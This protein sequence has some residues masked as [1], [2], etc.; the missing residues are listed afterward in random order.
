MDYEKALL[1]AR[2]ILTEGGTVIDKNEFLEK[3]E[4]RQLISVADGNE[5]K[6]KKYSKLISEIFRIHF[7]GNPEKHYKCLLDILEEMGRD[8]ITAKLKETQGKSLSQIKRLFQNAENLVVL[9]A[10]QDPYKTFDT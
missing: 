10:Q 7:K 2:A 5:L 3:L 4:E 9:Y 8:D 1:D 6:S